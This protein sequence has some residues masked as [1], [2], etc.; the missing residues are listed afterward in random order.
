[1]LSRVANSI[2]WMSRYLE[3]AENVARFI[4]VNLNLTLDLGEGIRQQ[5]EPLVSISGDLATFHQWYRGATREHVLRFLAFD[6]ENPNSI[7]A[8][9][10]AARENART[11]REILPTEL[12]EELNKIYLTVRGT[13]PDAVVDQPHDLLM[14][15]KNGSHLIVGLAE[16]S[17][18]HGEGWHFAQVGRLLERADKTS[19]ILDVK[20]FILL[21]SAAEVGTPIDLIQ[22]SAL[23]KSASAFQMYH[24]SR[25]RITPAQI[26][27]FLILDRT[28]P[29]SMHFCLINAERS[30]SEITGSPKGQ[31]TTLAEQQLSRLGSQFDFT[32]VDDIIEEGLHEFIDRF[33]TR[34]NLVDDGMFDTFFAVRPLVHVGEATQERPQ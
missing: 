15:V 19:R 33:Q 7:A 9:L 8:C 21:P 16:A 22:W 32:Y 5:W 26:A 27:D 20:Y 10:R 25:G 1:M 4:D 23:L 6:L 28:F 30:L 34:L 31:G 12:W 24:R 17:M 3:R 18:S 2:Y 14:R 29:R 11:I 13:D